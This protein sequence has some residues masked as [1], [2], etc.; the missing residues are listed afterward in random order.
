MAKRVRKFSYDFS[1][2]ELCFLVISFICIATLIFALGFKIGRGWQ[3]SLTPSIFGQGSRGHAEDDNPQSTTL[4]ARSEADRAKVGDKKP[5]DDLTFYEILPNMGK[6]KLEDI[7]PQITPEYLPI[8]PVSTSSKDLSSAMEKDKEKERAREKERE[9]E[10]ANL[11]Q[12]NASSTPIVPIQLGGEKK[13]TIQVSSFKDK[14]QA[15]ALE[16]KLKKKGFAAQIATVEIKDSGL[17]YRIRVGNF[18]DRKEAEKVAE[19]L[20]LQEHVPTFIAFLYAN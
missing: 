13:Y 1:S 6:I 15:Q 8:T 19:Q 14:A 20:R 12:A 18:K 16:A 5:V 17:W 11:A 4:M 7:K 9:K 2:R 3:L 10:R